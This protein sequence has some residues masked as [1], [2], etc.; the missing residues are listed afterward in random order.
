[1]EKR[2]GLFVFIDT[3]ASTTRI[4]SNVEYF[5]DFISSTLSFILAEFQSYLVFPSCKCKPLGDGLLIYYSSTTTLSEDSRFENLLK[6]ILTASFS[7]I[8]KYDEVMRGKSPRDNDESR[9]YQLGI[10]IGSGYLYDFE[11]KIAENKI[12]TIEDIGSLDLTYV[13]RLN[14]F[15]HPEGLVVESHLYEAYRK[16]FD[17][18]GVFTSKRKTIDEAF[19]NRLIYVSK[20]VILVEDEGDITRAYRDLGEYSVQACRDIIKNE[21]KKKKYGFA[22]P[23]EIRFMLFKCESKSIDEVFSLYPGGLI[24]SKKDNFPIGTIDEIKAADGIRYPHLIYECYY[25]RQIVFFAYSH[26]YIRNT[27]DYIEETTQRFYIKKD[28]SEI[29]EFFESFTLKPSSALAIPI[30]D[31]TGVHVKWIIALDSVETKVFK[32]TFYDH[33]GTNIGTYFDYQLRKILE[34]ADS[35]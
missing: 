32:T 3:R 20:E 28:S 13:F 11:Y 10:S 19:G 23:P 29:D 27:K 15:A 31:S 4:Y 9:K 30:F 34:N 1:M 33:L 6:S 2:Q 8:S 21:I 14:K 26:R 16:T 5:E 24:G 12:E 7:C 17:Q 25:E 18:C 22:V 35:K